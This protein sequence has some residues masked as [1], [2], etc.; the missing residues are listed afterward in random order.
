MSDAIKDMILNRISPVQIKLRAKEEGML[1]LREAGWKKVLVG[2]TTLQ[3][4]NR[5]TFEEDFKRGAAQTL[6]S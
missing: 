2:V 3:E 4:L 1:S 6:G 5:V